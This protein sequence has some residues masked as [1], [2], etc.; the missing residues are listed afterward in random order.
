M[1]KKNKKNQVPHC[2]NS[3]TIQSKNRTNEGK[4]DT[5]THIYMISVYH[6]SLFSW[7]R[8]GRYSMVHSS[9]IYNL[10][11]NECLFQLMF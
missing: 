8:P 2:Q 10:L 6:I 9:W 3:S 7:G 1:T 11:C 4:I 5:L